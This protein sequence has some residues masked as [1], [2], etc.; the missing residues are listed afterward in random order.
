MKLLIHNSKRFNKDL[1]KLLSQ[2]KNKVQSNLVSVSS[3]IKDIRKNGDKALLKY[4]KKFNKNKIII[5][6]KR[7]ISKT[8]FYFSRSL[9]IWIFWHP[10][11][12]KYPK[13]QRS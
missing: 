4:E 2:R 6:S 5:P 11:W 12:N 8:R 7:Q 3:I 1:N 9:G 13:L 10:C